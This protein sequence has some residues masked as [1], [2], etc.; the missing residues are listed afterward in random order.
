MSYLSLAL[1]GQSIRKQTDM[2]G[3]W[4]LNAG[5]KCS[6]SLWWSLV[7]PCSAYCPDTTHPT[8]VFLSEWIFLCFL[9]QIIKTNIV[10]FWR[11]KLSVCLLRLNPLLGLFL[12]LSSLLHVGLSLSLSSPGLQWPQT[13]VLWKIGLAVC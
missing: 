10:Y 5:V 2:Y 13:A 12:S 11:K 3:V 6:W 1:I 4:G 8:P 7:N 9:V